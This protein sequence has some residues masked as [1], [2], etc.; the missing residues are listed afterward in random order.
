METNR[1]LDLLKILSRNELY[2]F[3]EIFNSFENE[4]NVLTRRSVRPNISSILSFMR[5]PSKFLLFTCSAFVFPIHC[6][7]FILYCKDIFDNPLRRIL[8]L[9]VLLRLHPIHFGK[10]VLQDVSSLSFLKLL[11]DNRRFQNLSFR[12]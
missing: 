6:F 4:K 1:T 5:V 3:Q 8:R 7:E 10:T 9:K 2:F 11:E 12:Y